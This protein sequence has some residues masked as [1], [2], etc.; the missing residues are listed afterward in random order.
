MIRD[1]GLDKIRGYNMFK[2]LGLQFRISLY[3]GIIVFIIL[4]ALIIYTM[5]RSTNVASNLVFE[6]L[7]AEAKAEA[8]YVSS[9]IIHLN[10]PIDGIGHAIRTIATI[11]EDYNLIAPILDNFVEDPA[12][13]MATK[14]LVN[15]EP[16]YVNFNLEASKEGNVFKTSNDVSNTEWYKAVKETLSPYT[17]DVY[18]TDNGLEYTY[19]MPILVNNKFV[20]VIA[21]TISNKWVQDYVAS[22]VPFG[23]GSAFIVDDSGMLIGVDRERGDGDLLGLNIYESGWSGYKERDFINVVKEGKHLV[24]RKPS[25]TFKSGWDS[26][27]QLYPIPLGGGKHWG[28]VLQ[29][30]VPEILKDINNMQMIIII[31]SVIAFILL[32]MFIFVIIR[33][34]V[35]ISIKKLGDEAKCIAEGNMAFISDDKTLSRQDEMGMLANSFVTIKN[36]M[37]NTITL[38]NESTGQ[39]KSIALKLS[40][41]NNDLFHRTENQAINLEKTSAT[42]EEIAS[43][44]KVSTENSVDGNKMMTESKVSVENAA[45]VIEDTTRNI[46]E[47]YE[48]SSKIADI[49]KIIESIAFQTNILAL[50]AAVEAAR[51]GEQ[52]RGFAVVASEVRNLALTTQTSVNDISKLIEDANVKTKVATETARA[53]KEIFSD[54]RSKIEETSNI[55]KNLSSTAVEQQAGVD[56]V[57]NSVIE[58]S[59]ITQ[60]NTVL[61]DELTS[62]GEL[63]L[64]Q[65][66]NLVDLMEFF[67]IE[68]D[69][70]EE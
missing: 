41:G 3:I 35:I 38:I 52:G 69:V 33:R 28:I 42:M 34:L 31:G 60:Q 11:N 30:A 15:F 62:T 43:T 48:A 16:N 7:E 63:L 44:I 24:F 26:L 53:S 32:M 67:K 45:N 20:G 49:T 18:Q 22:I 64:S 55:M 5:N 47:V 50:N 13:E 12:H 4:S 17:T 70:T 39:I 1:L 29:V 27:Y 66:Q 10:M 8:N 36:N 21:T 61:V 9:R 54:I 25:S 2:K 51:A 57:N 59:D 56:Q 23:I 37:T 46:E 58:I 40:E 19:A 6:Q 65:A 68:A 14:L